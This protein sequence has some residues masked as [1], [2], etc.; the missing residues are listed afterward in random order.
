MAISQIQLLILNNSILFHVQDQQQFAF[1][2]VFEYRF[3]IVV[4]ISSSSGFNLRVCMSEH[5]CNAIVGWV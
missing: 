4:R 2:F 3:H 1:Y 5:H